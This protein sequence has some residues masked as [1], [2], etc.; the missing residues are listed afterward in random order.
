M[1]H[2]DV[3]PARYQ[4]PPDLVQNRRRIADGTQDPTSH[5]TA[6]GSAAHR[7]GFGNAPQQPVTRPEHIDALGQA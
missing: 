6:N 3:P 1:F 7:E 5:H 4:D 2:E